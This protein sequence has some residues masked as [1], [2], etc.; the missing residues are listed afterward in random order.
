MVLFEAN[1]NQTIDIEKIEAI[2]MESNFDSKDIKVV[3]GG[4][5]YLI[6]PEK[7][8]EFFQAIQHIEKG[9]SLSQQY[10]SV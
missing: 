8:R 6:S 9:S 4:I 5:S 10:V 1:Q 7:H 3:I 2:V